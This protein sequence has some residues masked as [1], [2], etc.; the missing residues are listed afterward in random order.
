MLTGIVAGTFHWHW[1]LVTSSL[2]LGWAIGA[3]SSA[4]DVWA[5]PRDWVGSSVC[6]SCHQ[7]AF[8]AWKRGP[9]AQAQNSL[10]KDRNRAQ[11][12]ACHT[13]G[14]AP[15]GRALFEQ[16]ECEACHGPGAAYAVGADIMRDP[17]LAAALGLVP[18]ATAEQRARVCRRCHQ[19]SLRLRPFDS[20]KAWQRLAHRYQQSQDTRN[21]QNAQNTQNGNVR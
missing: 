8:K 16:V 18:M 7:Q 19:Q 4:N 20:E 1:V 14:E 21:V 5:S 13:T 10:G 9:H 11:C 2:V 3:R 15:A 17:V 12:L 6:R